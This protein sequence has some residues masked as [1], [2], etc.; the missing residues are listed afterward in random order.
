M[1]QQDKAD[2]YVIATGETHSVR[3]C[4]EV[5]FDEAG[6]GDW[7]QYV[8]IDPQFLRPA[9]VDQLIGDSGQGQGATWAGSRRRPSRS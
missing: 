8:E 9:E 3:E 5:A 7:E 6:L 4:V 1:L 2:D